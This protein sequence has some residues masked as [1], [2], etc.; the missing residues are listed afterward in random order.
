M[1][2]IPNAAPAALLSAPRFAKSF[3]GGSSDECLTTVLGTPGAVSSL[4]PFPMPSFGEQRSSI[5]QSNHPVPPPAAEYMPPEVVRGSSR[6][7]AALSSSSSAAASSS[8]PGVA[9]AFA[10]YGPACDLWSAGVILYM[11]LSGTPP[12][13]SSSHPRLLRSIVAG[14]FSFDGA[15]WKHISA[16]AKA[17]IT[18]LLVVD[19]QA[20][21]TASAALAHPWMRGSARS[22]HSV[23]SAGLLKLAKSLA[24]AVSARWLL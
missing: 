24:R 5:R 8:S 1:L 13:S 11:L 12:F 7:R 18:K 19:P 6:V 21:L 15:A 9:A 20:R 23:R 2:S 16:E 22:V 10:P 3:R 17:L 4:T 14:A